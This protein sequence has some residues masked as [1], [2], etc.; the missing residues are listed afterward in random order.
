MK[1]KLSF[2]DQPL[3]LI[4]THNG[5]KSVGE[6]DTI[7]RLTIGPWKH[8]DRLNII[9]DEYRKA[10]KRAFMQFITNEIDNDA[11]PAYC[12]VMFSDECECGQ[13]LTLDGKCPHDKEPGHL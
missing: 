2:K 11:H 4:C 6:A 7:Y 12:D 13:I 9:Q 3:E 8:S 1:K 10:I 5:D